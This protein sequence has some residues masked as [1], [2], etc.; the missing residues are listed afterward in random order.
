VKGKLTLQAI[1]QRLK[2]GN[3]GVAL[4][5][6]G[7]SL[8]LRAILPPKPG[9]TQWKQRDIALKIYANPAGLERAEAEARKLG[10]LLACTVGATRGLGLLSSKDYN[11]LI[12]KKIAY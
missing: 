11:G 5:Q 6:K 3:L 10:A 1:N 8:Y 7:S 4:R 2:D 12:V 9:E